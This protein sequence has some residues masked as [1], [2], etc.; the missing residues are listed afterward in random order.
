MQRKAGSHLTHDER[1][2]IYAHLQG[3][4]TKRWIATTIGVQHSTIV[5]EIQRN[6]G[7]RGYRYKQAT[8]MAQERRHEASCTPHKMNSEMRQKIVGMLADTQASPQQISGRLKKVHGIS[9]S[10][11]SIYR[12]IVADKKLG[13]ELYLHLRHRHKKRNKRFGK[14]SGRGFIPDRIDIKDRPPEVEKKKRFGDM[15]LDTIVGKNHRGSIVSIVDRACK[16]TWLHGLRRRTAENVTAA[17]DVATKPLTKHG[18]VLT[19]TADNGKEFASHK[20]ITARTGAPVYFAT[21][22]HS[23][24]RGLNEHTNGLVRQYFPKGTDFTT[25]TKARINEVA[26]KLNNRPRAILNFETPMERLLKLQPILRG[27]AFHC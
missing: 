25:I 1:C 11:E 15:E 5:R 16:F 13:G 24:E 22:Y 23:W 19:F 18:L 6:K 8:Q 7:Q 21:P 12:H 10:H 14:K 3:G 17:I 20:A 2:Q 4:K 27:G 9:I 26:R